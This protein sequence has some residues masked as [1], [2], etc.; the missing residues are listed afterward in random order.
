MSCSSCTLRDEIFRVEHQCCA[1]AEPGFNN[2]LQAADNPVEIKIIRKARDGPRHWCVTP[3]GKR[4][5]RALEDSL[6]I[7][8]TQFQIISVQCVA[9]GATFIWVTLS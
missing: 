8:I 6:L 2:R 1:N 7:S 3:D 9:L 5:S 4:P